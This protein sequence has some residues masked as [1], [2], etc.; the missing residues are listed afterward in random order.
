MVTL[1]KFLEQLGPHTPLAWNQ[2]SWVSKKNIHSGWDIAR[3]NRVSYMLSVLIVIASTLKTIHEVRG[4]SLVDTSTSKTQQ[5]D[6]GFVPQ[7]IPAYSQTINDCST[8]SKYKFTTLLIFD[9]HKHALQIQYHSLNSLPWIR[10]STSDILITNKQLL[11][12]TQK[13]PISLTDSAKTT[14]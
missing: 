4:V 12:T 10:Q 7:M 11:F 5:E 9:A 3:I 2:K 14:A 8:S 1:A 6:T 13:K